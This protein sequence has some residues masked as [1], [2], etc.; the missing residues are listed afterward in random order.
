MSFIDGRRYPVLAA[1]SQT[2]PYPVGSLRLVPVQACT[3]M[4]W[5]DQR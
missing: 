1:P 2:R 4:S 5:A 3:A